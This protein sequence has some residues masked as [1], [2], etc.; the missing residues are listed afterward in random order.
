MKKSCI[1]CGSKLTWKDGLTRAGTQR[2]RC[3]NCGAR[4]IWRNK[5]NKTRKEQSWFKRWIQGDTISKI[6]QQSHYSPFKIK[7][8]IRYWLAQELPKIKYDYKS[9]KYLLLDGTYFGHDNCLI[10]LMDYPT[11]QVIGHSYTVRENYESVY[12]MGQNLAVKGLQP[13]SITVD[14]KPNVI[15]GVLAV[16]PQVRIQRCIYHI[17]HQGSMWLRTYPKTQAGRDLKHLIRGLGN[18][19]TDIKQ[20]FDTNYQEVIAQHETFIKQLS[21]KTIGEKDV[22]KALALLKHAYGNMWHY[23]QDNNIPPTN[24]KLEGYFSELKQQYRKHKGL[25][26]GHREAYLKWYIYYK[27][28]SKNTTF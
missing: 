3:L 17:I 23:R 2:Y 21:S 5:D 19:E 14:G 9:I 22:K 11:G 13:I 27:N 26:K 8:I 7:Q 28:T 12:T 10:V 24:N 4:Y 15:K 20:S 18:K 16:W 6:A 25:S 1:K